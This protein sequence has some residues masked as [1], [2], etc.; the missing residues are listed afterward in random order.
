[1][2]NMKENALQLYN[3]REARIL[4]AIA[5]KE[6]DRVPIVPLFAFFNCYF[7]GITPREAFTVPVKAMDAWRKTVHH[8]KPDATYNLNGAISAIDEVLSGLDFKA[9]KW[10]GHGVPDDQS[11]QFVEAE[12]MHEDEYESFFNDPGS[13]F[14]CKMLPRLAGNLKG[15]AKLPPME[16]V[17]LGYQ[18]PAVLPFFSDPEV[19]LALETL[20]NV[21][22]KQANW[23]KIF[24]EFAQELREAGFPS[25]KEQTVFVPYDIVADNIRGTSGAATDLFV[26]PDNLKRLV[27]RM[28]P[29]VTNAAINGARAK[30]NL[31]VFLPLHKGTDSFMSP[32]QFNTYYWPTLQKLIYDLVEAGCTPYL[33]IEGAYNTRLDIIKEV[34]KGKC[35]YHFEATDIFEAKKKLG[36][37]VCIMGNMPNSLLATGSVEQV[38]EYTKKLID[39]CGDGGGYIMSAGA[40]I[41]HAKTEN[42]EAWFETTRE[43]GQYR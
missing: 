31:R 9:M 12:Y 39:V 4:D 18:W 43:Y 1:M 3:Q 10:P 34:P 29:F 6:P 42:V 25:M 27:E 7:A 19:I 23:V 32:R 26:Q 40:L 2:F 28:A 20:I 21:S 41:D 16:T 22:K 15:L 17:A 33:L 37:T 24:S 36:D 14:L 35:I 30:G 11:F 38:K 13:F 5:L 8:F